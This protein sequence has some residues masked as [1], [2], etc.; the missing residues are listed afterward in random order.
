MLLS[1]MGL[2]VPIKTLSEGRVS[3]GVMKSDIVTVRVFLM[4]GSPSV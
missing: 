4:H 2:K 1:S 3:S